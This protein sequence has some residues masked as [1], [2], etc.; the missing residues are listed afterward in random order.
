MFKKTD[1]IIG[2]VSNE[3]VDKLFDIYNSLQVHEKK[4]NN[5]HFVYDSINKKTV[6]TFNTIITVENQVNK[7]S[8]SFKQEITKNFRFDYIHYLHILEYLEN[9]KLDFHNHF[10]N[11]YYSYIVY[12]DNNGGTEFKLD[13]GLFFIPSEKCKLVIFPSEIYHRAVINGSHRIVGAGGIFKK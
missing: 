1:F 6:E 4:L 9:S 12:M 11:E 8:D 3:L 5:T 10:A 2:Y 13:E 7:L